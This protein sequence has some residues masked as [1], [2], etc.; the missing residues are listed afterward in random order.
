MSFHTIDINC[1]EGQLTS[2][3]RQLVLKSRDGK[4][5][6]PIE[7]IS[8]VIVNGFDIT[9]HKQ[10]L[11]EMGN[12]DKPLIICEKYKPVSILLPTSRSTDTL[13][14]RKLATLSVKMKAALWKSLIN[15]KCENQSALC[16]HILQY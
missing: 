7:D 13:L 14:T 4:K 1:I 12:A 2:N 15:A 11:V 9:I 3:D 5:S 10:L 16:E 8:S 6:L